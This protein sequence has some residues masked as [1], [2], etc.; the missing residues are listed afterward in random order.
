MTKK[1]LDKQLQFRP[2]DIRATIDR[3]IKEFEKVRKYVSIIEQQRLSTLTKCS[4][5]STRNVR[6]RIGMSYFCNSCG[7][8]SRR[9][10]EEEK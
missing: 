10:M 5:C 4:R 1:N 2:I 6:M 7:Y 9:D 8:D 3:T